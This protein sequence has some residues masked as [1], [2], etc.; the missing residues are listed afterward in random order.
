MM[1]VLISKLKAQKLKLLTTKCHVCLS[2]CIVFS[3]LTNLNAQTFERIENYAGLG[4]ATQN[5]G[6]ALADYD[7]DGDLDIFVVAKAQDVTGSSN[8]HSKL[9]RNNNDGTFTD[10]TNTTGLVNLFPVDEASDYTDALNGFKY[11][12]FW[13]D[14]D[15][16]GYPDIFFTHIFKVQ[17]FHNEGDGT[18]KEVTQEA[19]FKKYNQNVNTGA[20]WFDYNNDGFLDIYISDWGSEDE[21]NRLFK[22]NGDG[23]FTNV[24]SIIQGVLVNKH[25][26]QSVPFDFN[27]DGWMDLYVANDYA[28]ESN[29]LYINNKG[30]GFTEEAATYGLDFSK[31]DMGIAVGDYNGDG[32]FDMYI[33]AIGDNQLFENQGNNS[34]VNKGRSLGVYNTGWAWDVVFSDF[35]LDRDEDLFVVN[36][37]EFGSSGR[38]KNTYYENSIENFVSRL[39]DSST[40]VGLGEETISVT[41][42]VF[43]YDNDGDLDIFVT[44]NDGPSYFY[45]NKLTDVNQPAKDLHWFK[46]KLE[47]TTSNRDA[48]GTTLSVKTARGLLHRYYS[49]K[50]FLSQ[51]LKP[52]HFGLGSDTEILELKITWPSGLVETHTNIPADKTILARE[53][54]GYQILDVQPSIKPYG[55]MDPNSCNYNPDATVNTWSCNYLE[56][57]KITGTIKTHKT[58]I[59]SYS[60][61]V[62]TDISLTWKV[63]GGEIIEEPGIGNIIVK[64]GT[65][66]TGTIT[67]T[68]SNAKC[69]SEPVVLSVTLLDEEV[70]FKEQSIA[71]L[72]NETLLSLIRKDYARPTVHARN[73]FHTSVVLY[74]AWALYDDKASTYLIGNNLHGFNSNFEGF[75]TTENLIEARKKTISYAAYRLLSERFAHAPNPSLSQSIL[76]EVMAGLGYDISNTDTDYTTGNPIAL[77]NFIASEMIA[78]GLQDGSNEINQYANQY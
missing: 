65:G 49:G 45:E 39:V 37:F 2:I 25:S 36:G 29:D 13:G 4:T 34:F 20:T 12:A 5:N 60:Y 70:N 16:D 57:S 58:S 32:A 77:G 31:D 10:I 3:F 24:T 67:L 15:N 62:T 69:I 52:V 7:A 38:Y 50:G 66:S 72:W 76:D 71:R 47:G 78:Y 23:T 46:V 14:Y 28:T 41:E 56:T 19:G 68:A 21:G 55:C 26:Y 63:T 17:L 74:D 33:T 30:L 61:P 43:D 44:N 8:T 64:W 54:N 73:L 42:A 53:G 40:R 75:K 59:E 48:I 35:D 22:N 6:T 18:F 51:H 9:F 1:E 27:G 11:G